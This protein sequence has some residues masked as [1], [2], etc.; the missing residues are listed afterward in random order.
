M[1]VAAGCFAILVAA[2]IGIQI[3]NGAFDE[4]ALLF[5]A[6]FVLLAIIWWLYEFTTSPR[7]RRVL[8]LALKWGGIL[9]LV[10]FVLGFVG[11]IIF[12]PGANQG[13]LLGILFTGPIGAIG[14][15]LIGAIYGLMSTSAPSPAPPRTPQ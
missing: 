15:A 11:P 10:L 8:V 3:R 12:T 6:P 14:G 9:G 2:L 13:P 5:D 4:I 7:I 1:L